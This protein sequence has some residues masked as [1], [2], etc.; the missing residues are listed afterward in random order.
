MSFISFP[1]GR[2]S[3]K[4]PISVHHIFDLH[5]FQEAIRVMKSE[6]F[7]RTPLGKVTLISFRIGLP[8]GML[9]ANWRRFIVVGYTLME[10][11]WGL[12]AM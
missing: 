11:P 2:L 5:F 4:H 6:S 3:Q 8:L 9:K 12:D 1:Y 10:G 7:R